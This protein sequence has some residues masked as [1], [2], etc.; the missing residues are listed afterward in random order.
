MPGV[1]HGSSFWPLSSTN[2]GSS[3]AVAADCSSPWVPAIHTGYLDWFPVPGSSTS[4]ASGI[5]DIWEMNQHIATLRF[6]SSLSNKISPPN[7]YSVTYLK[8]LESSAT[9]PNH[10]SSLRTSHPA[11]ILPS[12]LL[13]GHRHHYLWVCAQAIHWEFSFAS[14]DSF[15][16]ISFTLTIL[17]IILALAETHFPPGSPP[18]HSSRSYAW[19]MR[20][21]SL[22]AL[23]FSL[24]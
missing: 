13:I 5:T 24:L 19:C 16:P 1:F 9:A 2:S 20:A 10:P 21:S 15:H 4:P 23:C 14:S 8:T 6:L 3:W 12:V 11:L 22:N 7:E 18:W 17:F